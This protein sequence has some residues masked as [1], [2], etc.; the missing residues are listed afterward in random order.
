[1]QNIHATDFLKRGDEAAAGVG[2]KD[3]SHMTSGYDLREPLM[4]A[5]LI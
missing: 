1:M 3:M 5:T 2:M 4:Q